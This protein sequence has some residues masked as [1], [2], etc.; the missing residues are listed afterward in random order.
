MMRTLWPEV[1][2]G[3][4]T[5]G[6]AEA[7]DLQLVWH[8]TDAVF[9]LRSGDAVDPDRE[10]D[11]RDRCFRMWTDGALALAAH[12]AGLSTPERGSGG[13][14]LVMRKQVRRQGG[15]PSQGGAPG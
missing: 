4:W 12:A 11:A 6:I 1:T 13:N 3:N 8:A 9:A 10:L 15:S 5:T 2:E 7:E 14:L